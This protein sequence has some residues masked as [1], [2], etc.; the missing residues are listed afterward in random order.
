MRDFKNYLELKKKWHLSRLDWIKQISSECLTPA[1][2]EELRTLEE[3]DLKWKSIN[4]EVHQK[5]A[6]DEMDPL[7]RGF[8]EM[9]QGMK[10]EGD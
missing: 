1:L 4:P 9:E 8:W 10:N 3:E 7:M 5:M 6:L 2:K